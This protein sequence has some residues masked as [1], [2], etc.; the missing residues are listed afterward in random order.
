MKHLPFDDT[1]EGDLEEISDKDQLC[2]ATESEEEQDSV[3]DNDG[4]L[5]RNNVG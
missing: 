4:H 1:L 5:V 3:V 2:S